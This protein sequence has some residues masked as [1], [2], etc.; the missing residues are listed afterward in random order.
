MD[1]HLKDWIKFWKN[2][3]NKCDEEIITKQFN[4]IRKESVKEELLR[5]INKTDWSNGE[6]LEYINERLKKL[7]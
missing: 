4:L 1:K 6:I 7:L 5:I 3:N 2:I